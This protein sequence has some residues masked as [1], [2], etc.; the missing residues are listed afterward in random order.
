MGLIAFATAG[1][2]H[3]NFQVVGHGC[4]GYEDTLL[5]EYLSSRVEMAW[6]EAQMYSHVV[7]SR[8]LAETPKTI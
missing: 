3:D 2:R 4:R 1:C 6:D 7:C 5:V 8:H